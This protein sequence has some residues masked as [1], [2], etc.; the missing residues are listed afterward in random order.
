[1]RLL[2][3]EA[4]SGAIDTLLADVRVGIGRALAVRGEPGTGKTALLDYAKQRAAR[5]AVL[6][7]A[8]VEA[9]SD[10]AFAGLHELLRPVLWP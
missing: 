1:L 6:S 10:L 5:M 4:E 3:R 8:G 2:G 9:E 7:A